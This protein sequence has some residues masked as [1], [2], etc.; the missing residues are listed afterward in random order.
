MQRHRQRYTGVR[1]QLNSCPPKFQ[2]AGSLSA[3]TSHQT[4]HRPA[5][6]TP[7]ADDNFGNNIS[8]PLCMLHTVAT[9]TMEMEMIPAMLITIKW[10]LQGNENNF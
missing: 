9:V 5:F 8:S 2:L 4:T 3:N 10:K 1:T 7:E 6:E